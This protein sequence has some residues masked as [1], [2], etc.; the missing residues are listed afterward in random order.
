M[1][2]QENQQPQE[3]SVAEKNRE[4]VRKWKL[5]NPLK[6]RAQLKRYDQQAENKAKRR[7]RIAAARA[8]APVSPPAATQESARAT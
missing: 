1:A 7:A 5:A 8:P 2:S 4:R 6:V 3:L